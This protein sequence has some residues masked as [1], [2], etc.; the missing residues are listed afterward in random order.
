[1]S[2][3]PVR[4]SPRKRV[5]D[6]AEDVENELKDFSPK[7]P[8]V[9]PSKSRVSELGKRRFQRQP[10]APA[11]DD[12]D[13]A[14]ETPLSPANSTSDLSSND[15][16]SPRHKTRR[17]RSRNESSVSNQS[18]QSCSTEG[19]GT[20]TWST[21]DSPGSREFAAARKRFY[22]TVIPDDPTLREEDAT[23]LSRR[24]K[25]I[26]FG[27]NTKAYAKYVAEVRKDERT[28]EMPWTPNKYQKTS[29]RSFDTQ[30][31]LWKLA[32]HEWDR[33][34]GEGGVKKEGVSAGS[35]REHEQDDE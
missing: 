20:K 13:E 25:Q 3:T 6:W 15:F 21:S 23:V 34:S 30:V 29:R 16:A 19:S 12:D 2:K 18:G 31:K 10:A 35:E 22:H 28:A 24:Q 8:N 33:A 26:D 5:L 27:K 7:K 11:M 14:S 9:T 4:Q 1:M 32:V 17:G